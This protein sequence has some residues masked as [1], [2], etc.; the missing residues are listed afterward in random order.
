MSLSSEA[1][2]S[3]VSSW[4][5]GGG[6]GRAQTTTTSK[7]KKQPNK[8]QVACIP[9]RLI[10]QKC[11][12]QRPCSRC[13]MKGKLHLCVDEA[14]PEELSQIELEMLK[15]K[16][17]YK[18]RKKSGTQES[19]EEQ[20]SNEKKSRKSSSSPEL[21]PVEVPD[22]P[23]EDIFKQ[24]FV[25]LLKPTHR[26]LVQTKS[27]FFIKQ[28]ITEHTPLFRKYLTHLRALFPKEEVLE[29]RD[30]MFQSAA[31]TVTDEKASAEMMESLGEITWF[32]TTPPVHIESETF[33]LPRA[34]L[35]LLDEVFMISRVQHSD[36]AIVQAVN[37]L[38]AN[39]K[40]SMSLYY[41]KNMEKIMGRS[42][43]SFGSTVDSQGEPTTPFLMR[44]LS[45]KSLQ[46]M[47]RFIVSWIL[48][49]ESFSTDTFEIIQPDGTLARCFCALAG[50][51]EANEIGSVF[52]IMMRPCSATFD[53][54][55]SPK[56]SSIT[57]DS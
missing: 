49:E 50:V 34:L 39:G 29:L 11:D 54:E 57:S 15:N 1:E 4:E 41:N 51:H 24:M 46:A 3:S 23:Q 5:A 30:I 36:V 7:R 42:V 8:V 28:F 6:G 25:V 44:V 40:L 27:P 32:E 52:T 38:D 9:C 20:S 2:S 31:S 21:V 16:R 47:T 19:I 13:V 17:K 10:K 37:Q 22:T 35:P 12:L 56:Q 33:Y 48:R 55:G 43:E 18:K 14:T 53:P 45:N 26:T